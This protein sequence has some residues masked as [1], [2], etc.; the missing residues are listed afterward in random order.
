MGAPARREVRPAKSKQES[1]TAAPQKRRPQ[2]GRNSTFSCTVRSGLQVCTKAFE[3]I[4]QSSIDA[5]N[6]STFA[7]G[8]GAS[9][10]SCSLPRLLS[11]LLLLLLLHGQSKVG[12]PSHLIN[13]SSGRPHIASSTP[14]LA[15]I[16]RPTHLLRSDGRLDIR[17]PTTCSHPSL[18]NPRSSTLTSLLSLLCPLFCRLSPL[19]LPLPSASTETNI[20]SPRSAVT[21]YSTRRRPAPATQRPTRP[22][23]LARKRHPSIF[24]GSHAVVRARRA[25]NG[26]SWLKSRP[27]DLAIFQ[28]SRPPALPKSGQQRGITAVRYH[29]LRPAAK[30]QSTPIPT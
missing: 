11:P 25:G 3:Q 17:N 24:P 14:L 15:R 5:S 2:H 18:L 30:S 7:L 20:S 19:A 10:I 1:R 28:A 6:Q 16:E 23:R 21:L 26:P 27:S 4:V 29:R 8:C 22:A 9:A 13:I 12:P